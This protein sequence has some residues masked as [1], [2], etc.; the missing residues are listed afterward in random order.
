MPTVSVENIGKA[1]YPRNTI[2]ARTLQRM[3][4]GVTESRFS[5]LELQG[6]G[7]LTARKRMEDLGGSIKYRMVNETLLEVT[8]TAGQARG[9]KTKQ[10]KIEEASMR[11]SEELET[12][13]SAGKSETYQE[14]SNE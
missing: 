11:I 7:I 8:M 1:S 9:Q 13:E 12:E 2:L 6:R 5:V 14:S 3:G 10:E 4:V